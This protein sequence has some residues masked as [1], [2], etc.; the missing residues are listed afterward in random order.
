MEM[1]LTKKLKTMLDRIQTATEYIKA[2]LSADVETAIILGSGLGDFDQEMEIETSL[3]YDKIP[4]F[5]QSTVEGHAGQL[6]IG[7]VS[8]VPV[9]VLKGRFHYYEGY[10]L[11]EATFPIRVFQQLSVKQI[12]LSNASGGLDPAQQIGD[13][14]IIEDHMHLFADNPLRGLNNESLGP[15]FP[16]MSQPYSFK[17][18]ELAEQIGQQH[19]LDL[20]KGVYAGTPGP[21][22]ETKA[23]Y[24]YFRFIGADAV[25][26]S[27]TP[28]TIVAVHAGMKIFGVSVIADMG[29]EGMVVEISHDDVQSVAQKSAPKLRCLFRELVKNLAEEQ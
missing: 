10:S 29:V 28:E 26:M 9:I 13:L 19:Q 20:K 22:Y 14:M 18:I 1:I 15:R 7:T 3:S 16:D 6:L 12:L 24:K 4:H 8:A 21:N 27:T 2:H 17:L 23:E 11:K 25:G 5:P